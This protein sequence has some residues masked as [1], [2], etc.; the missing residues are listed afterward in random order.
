MKGT[1]LPD[2][3]CE[4]KVWKRGFRIVAGTDEVGRGSWAGALVAAAVVWPR[5][6]ESNFNKTNKSVTQETVEQIGINDS[7]KLRPR[8][9]E[10]F[11]KFIKENCLAWGIGEVPVAAINR[12]GMA[13]ATKMAFRRA[14]AASNSKIDF[15]L[16]DAFYVP[17]A[18]GIK[19]KNQLAIVKGDEK[20]ISIAAAS[21]IAKVYRDRLM[22]K[23]AQKH[24]EYKWAKNKGYGTREHQ[25]AILKCGLTRLH[26]RAFVRKL[27]SNVNK[28]NK[29][30]KV[31][32][33]S[34]KIVQ[35]LYKKRGC[36]IR[37]FLRD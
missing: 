33:K 12:L 11:A 7:K 24:P 5:L 4:K 36:K 19:R 21:I 34:A 31:S 10:K 28:D 1:V 30:N 27:L 3:S 2:F 6:D 15:L 17:Y 29:I 22:R 8:Q 16:V 13:K 35:C 32:N 25:D 37:S 14:L 9:R 20:S 18:R 26:R 23:L